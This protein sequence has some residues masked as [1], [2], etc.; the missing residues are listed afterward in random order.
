MDAS[1]PLHDPRPGDIVEAVVCDKV[2]V[3]L[4]T[5]II[6]E[7]LQSITFDMFKDG[8][9]Y[10]SNRAT[11]QSWQMWCEIHGAEDRHRANE[12]I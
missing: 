6:H 2:I 3:C 11:L 10:P 5:M 1:S 7:D 9:L 8:E 4:V 12:Q